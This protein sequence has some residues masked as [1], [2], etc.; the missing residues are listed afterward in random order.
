MSAR[1]AV[2]T[3]AASSS[4]YDRPAQGAITLE[5]RQLQGSEAIDVEGTAPSGAPVTITLLAM[6][7]TDLPTILVSRHDVVTDV[8]G[9][10]RA[11]IPAA[12]AYERGTLLRV[13]ATSLPGVRPASAQLVIGA[14]NAGVSI[15][16]E[17]PPHP[18]R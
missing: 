18:A 2:V 16:L 17:Q 15:P 13:V 7:S 11:V 12:S 6:L 5:A 9:R 10:F 3:G 1:V 8:N 4:T 14:P